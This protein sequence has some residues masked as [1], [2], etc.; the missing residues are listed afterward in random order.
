[1][2]KTVVKPN[3]YQD[4]VALM[5]LS[6]KLSDLEG[7]SKVSVMMGTPANKDI[8]RNTGFGSAEV[9]AAQP[10]DLVLGIEADDEATADQVAATALE[11]LNNQSSAKGASSLPRVRSLHRALDKLPGANVALVSV[12]GEHAAAQTRE[13]LESG[14]NVM[15]FSDNVSVDDEVCLKRLADERGLLMM[16]PD[17]GTSAIAGVPLAFVNSTRPGSIGIVGASGTGTQEVMSQVDRLGLGTSHAVGVGGRDLTAP[18]G[19][20]TTLAALRAL[21]DDQA[22]DTIVIVSKPPA[23][24]VRERVVAAAQQLTKPVVALFL[25]ERP[26]VEREGTVWFV[27]TMAEAAEKAVELAGCSRFSPAPGQRTI[28]G[29]YTGGTLAGEAAMVL[30]QELDLP[31]DDGNHAHGVQLDAEGHRIIDLGDDEYTQGRPHPMIDPSSR[32]ERIGEVFDDESVAVLLLD[33][34]LGH[35]STEDPAGAVATE[36]R[37]GIERARAAGREVAVVASL[38]GTAQD[39]QD[40]E[41]QRRTL[42]QAGVTVLPSNAAAARHAAGLVQLAAARA[43][44]PEQQAAPV[45]PAVADLL[46]GPRVVNV[47]LAGFAETIAAQEQAVVQW[48]WQPLAGG[49]AR[50]SS[51][52]TQLMNR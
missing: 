9:D 1:M 21:D 36:V 11:M 17:C 23:P 16:G 12:P 8:L 26:E 5:V 41:A 7:V 44:R 29:L 38:C 30:R 15:V 28:R 37:E 43:A 52:V 22:T 49:D 4:S 47:G 45:P 48:T 39:F 27:A 20:T 42:Q 14:L 3:L 40:L 33:V 46:A 31:A 24:E 18:V 10:G 25:G 35:G 19:G 34:V 32:S 50:L 51:L 13:L 2:L 6:R